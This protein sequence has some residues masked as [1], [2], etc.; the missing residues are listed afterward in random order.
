MPYD[1]NKMTQETPEHTAGGIFLCSQ[2]CKGKN[3]KFGTHNMVK[4]SDDYIDEDFFFNRPPL[5][6]TIQH[7]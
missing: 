4:I 1:S 3:F 7:R 6:L 2:D 5:R